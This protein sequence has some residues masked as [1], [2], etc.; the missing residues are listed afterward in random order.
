MAVHQDFV[1]KLKER[2][3]QD[4]VIEPLPD[5]RCDVRL[6]LRNGIRIRRMYGVD[7]CVTEH[8]GLIA[9]RDF[10]FVTQAN[11]AQLNR[12]RATLEF[13]DNTLKH[14]DD[15]VTVKREHLSELVVLAERWIPKDGIEYC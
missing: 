13:W 3:P 15:M 8:Q 5:G 7:E 11:T 9:A 12:D 2:G 10:H 1:R 14:G 6:R 4:L